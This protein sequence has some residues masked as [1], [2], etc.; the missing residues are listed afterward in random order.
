MIE[1]ELVPSVYQGTVLR[2]G[3][4]PK[5]RGRLDIIADIISACMGG[6]TKS[7]VM[8]RAKT[9][10]VTITNIMKKLLLCGL[11]SATEEEGNIMFF[12]TTRGIDF[13]RNYE[14]LLGF[15]NVDD[16]V[17]MSRR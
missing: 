7:Y 5:N 15:L 6:R 13:L 1:E 16:T 17:T 4:T 14:K 10:S 3:S 12:P 9:N 8:L 2:A 11:I